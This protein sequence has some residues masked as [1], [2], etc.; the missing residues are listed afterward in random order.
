[1][2]RLKSGVV[3]AVDLRPYFERYAYVE[4]VV[5]KDIPRGHTGSEVMFVYNFFSSEMLEGFVEYNSNEVFIGPIV[6]NF[7]Y[8]EID[9]FTY[10]GKKK[11]GIQINRL[12]FFKSCEFFFDFRDPNFEPKEW[13][14]KDYHVSE[15]ELDFELYPKEY[16][17][18]TLEFGT[19]IGPVFI[20]QI[21]ILEYAKYT[22]QELRLSEEEEKEFAY[23][24]R[25]SKYFPP[26]D[27]KEVFEVLN[28]HEKLVLAND[29]VLNNKAKVLSGLKNSK[30]K[31][32]WQWLKNSE[33]ELLDQFGEDI[34]NM[35]DVIYRQFIKIGSESTLA[36]EM[37]EGN[38][39]ILTITGEGIKDLMTEVIDI[40]NQAPVLVH[41]EIIAFQQ[42]DYEF[43]EFSFEDSFVYKLDEFYFSYIC[44]DGMY[45]LQVYIG[46]KEELSEY[47]IQVAFMFLD[48]QLGEYRVMT[49]VNEIDFHV[50]EKQVNLFKLSEI[51]KI[52]N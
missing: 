29:A 41:F 14:L 16:N 42:P 48:A 20:R 27:I 13:F 18:D 19:R 40:F 15:L 38:R 47:D 1:M 17:F 44:E 52:I 8:H 28:K 24:K 23:L 46:G 49:M 30:I 51:S 22:Q 6:I 50:F 31:K 36:L 32:F 11:N 34:E 35:L 10:L 12:P 7:P 25:K 39:L 4:Y 26:R 21:I 9:N 5:I 37:D 33:S 2:K 43:T 3:F 45:N